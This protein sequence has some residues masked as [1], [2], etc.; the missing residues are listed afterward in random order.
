MI[1]KKYLLLTVI[2]ALITVGCGP[3]N[4]TS[5]E[6]T[7]TSTTPTTEPQTSDVC[8]EL[9]NKIS[10]NSFA[11]WSLYHSTYSYRIFEGIRYGSRFFSTSGSISKEI[12]SISSKTITVDDDYSFS[13]SGSACPPNDEA[14]DNIYFNLGTT[15]SSILSNLTYAVNTMDT[16][17]NGGS[18]ERVGT[19]LYKVREYNSSGGL[20][21][22]LVI[23]FSYPSFANPTLYVDY[24][25]FGYQITW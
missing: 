16:T 20:S 8:T 6:S 14:F 2:T 25:G 10:S 9:K 5:S 17:T 15:E 11:G 7:T 21:R 4:K 24:Y 18:C 13:C 22:V 19:S 23:D 12:S 3:G 1:F